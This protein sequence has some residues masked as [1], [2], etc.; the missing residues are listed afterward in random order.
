MR[1]LIPGYKPEPQPLGSFREAVS[2][3]LIV[4]AVYKGEV[5]FLTTA[6]KYNVAKQRYITA[7]GFSEPRS[8]TGN[9][10]TDGKIEELDKR[11]LNEMTNNVRYFVFENLKEFAEAALREGWEFA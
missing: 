5:S 4:V 2:N 7:W 6:V 11:V 1:K 9:S 3:G 8:K 10:W